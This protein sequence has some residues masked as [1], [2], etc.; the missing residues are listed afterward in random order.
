MGDAE[1]VARAQGDIA[2]MAEL[3]DQICAA[4]AANRPETLEELSSSR[5]AVRPLFLESS[6]ALLL[7]VTT[8]GRTDLV[9]FLR[10]CTA[11]VRH[12]DERLA[13]WI[14]DRS[15]PQEDPEAIAARAIDGLFKGLDP[16]EWNLQ[17]DLILVL[18]SGRHVV[19]NILSHGHRRVVVFCAKGHAAPGLPEEVKRIESV[20]ELSAD[21]KSYLDPK[22]KRIRLVD[23]SDGGLSD[24]L[25]GEVR[26]VASRALAA[27]NAVENTI[28]FFSE[29]WVL[30]GIENLPDVARLPTTD[31]LANALPK[32]PAVIVSAGPSLGKNVRLLRELGGRAV[33]IAVAHA[34]GALRKEGVVPHFVACTDAQDLSWQFEG[35]GPDSFGALL[36][37]ASSHPSLFRLSPRSFTF[38]GNADAEKWM[39]LPLED[40]KVPMIVAGGSV[41]HTCFSVA[42]HLG[43][44]PIILVGQDLAFEGG[45]YYAAGIPDEHATVRF[46]AGTGTYLVTGFSDGFAKVAGVADDPSRGVREMSDEAPGY[47]GGTVPTSA[48]F[49][50]YRE[51]FES[52]AAKLEDET[53][54]FNCTEGGAFIKGFAHVPLAQVLETLAPLSLDAAAVVESAVRMPDRRQRMRKMRGFVAASVEGLDPA[55]DQAR[56]CM[57]LLEK[58]RRDPRRASDL[59]RA[60]RQLRERIKAA[61]FVSVFCQNAIM[62]TLDELHAAKTSADTLDYSRTLYAAV[63]TST[64]RVRGPLERALAKLDAALA[65]EV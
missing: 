55:M 21:F 6:R 3:S 63:E 58:V 5:E 32:Q 14:K 36:L 41:S 35:A 15:A 10:G 24:D 18:G 40:Q 53:K 50:L 13:Q 17:R 26:A 42:A 34:V 11:R 23:M 31:A 30:Q 16:R 60:E 57:R 12:A 19:N 65:A 46:D 28:R 38:C 43:C 37:T 1:E 22:P 2:R 51:W 20:A 9:S 49:N 4:L 25:R 56:H 33:I 64:E 44:D 39:F 52:R 29:R 48:A 62:S 59:S 47:Y 61:F 54:L 7:L 8:D 27:I 45:R